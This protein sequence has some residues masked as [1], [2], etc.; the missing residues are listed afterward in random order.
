MRDVRASTLT[1]P[2]KTEASVVTTSQSA[3]CT[4]I[5]HFLDTGSTARTCAPRAA[6]DPPTRSL[7]CHIL[8]KGW[9]APEAL[10]YMSHICLPRE[11]HHR[12]FAFCSN[13]EQ[14][15]VEE[16]CVHFVVVQ[17]QAHLHHRV[18]SGE[19]STNL[20]LHVTSLFLCVVDSLYITLARSLSLYM[21]VSR[22]QKT[23]SVEPRGK[24]KVCV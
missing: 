2:W 14:G 6:P 8:F 24:L 1:R 23:P 19:R 17:D 12:C 22:T 4:A 16:V 9:A 7:L 15:P 20:L 10:V 21:L 5:L 3:P 13:M 11:Y 18:E